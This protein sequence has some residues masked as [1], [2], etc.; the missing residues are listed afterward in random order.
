MA[1]LLCNR[2]YNQMI[3]MVSG[4]AVL[5]APNDLILQIYEG[6]PGDRGV[7]LRC[8]LQY[9]ARRS[10]LLKIDCIQ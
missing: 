6:V 9:T 8:I 10:G 3:W 2:L 5:A 4:L 7:R 1:K